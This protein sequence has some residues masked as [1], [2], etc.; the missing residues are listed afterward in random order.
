LI[1]PY[2][3]ANH[4]TRSAIPGGGPV[5]ELDHLLEI[6]QLPQASETIVDELP[7]T[8]N[9]GIDLAVPVLRAAARPVEKAF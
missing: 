4:D 3:S 6:F 8:F 7:G 5:F 1:P 2:I 9:I